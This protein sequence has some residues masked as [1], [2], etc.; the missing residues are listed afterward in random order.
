MVGLDFSRYL[1]AQL[2]ENNNKFVPFVY[3]KY[4]YIISCFDY[5]LRAKKLLRS[6]Q[7]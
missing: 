4:S 1:R 7:R 3:A 6:Y 2:Y 5:I